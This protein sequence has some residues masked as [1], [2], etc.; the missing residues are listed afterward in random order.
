MTLTNTHKTLGLIAILII[1]ILIGVF[2]KKCDGNKVVVTGPLD[3]VIYW[4]DKYNNEVA[5][6]KGY[7]A[8]FAYEEKKLLD[9]IAKVHNSKVKYIKEYLTV[10]EEGKTV[11]VTKDKPVITYVD[12]GKGKEIKNVFQM[13]ENPY[14]IAEATIDLTGKD[15]SK[16][17]LQTVDTLS[18]VWKEVKEGNIFHRKTFLQLDVTNKNPYNQIT[19]LQAYRVALPKPKKFGVGIVAGYGF[20]DGITPRVFIGAGIS[21]NPIRF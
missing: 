3:S 15:S 13:F 9:S 5:S 6:L 4:K 7:E 2:A 19:G 12:S 1:L 17:A 18:V 14:Y 11:I 8:Q 10:T 21:Y 20:S 16:L